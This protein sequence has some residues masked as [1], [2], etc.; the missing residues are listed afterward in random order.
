MY[1]FV[2][3]S[4][5]RESRVIYKLAALPCPG[6]GYSISPDA[7]ERLF[8]TGRPSLHKIAC[9]DEEYIIMQYITINK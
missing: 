9:F 2:H 3:A 8:V 1:I 4:S 7:G 5:S 6:A